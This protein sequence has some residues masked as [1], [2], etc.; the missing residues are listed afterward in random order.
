MTATEVPTV[1]E[2]ELSN[3]NRITGYLRTFGVVLVP[4]YSG[5]LRLDQLQYEHRDAFGTEHACVAPVRYRSGTRSLALRARRDRLDGS[6]PAIERFLGDPRI[7]AV[8]RGYLGFD[9][10]V[11]NAAYLMLD[12][13]DRRDHC[14][15]RPTFSR[16][17]E[18][19]LI[20]RT[21]FRRSHPPQAPGVSET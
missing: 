4:A 6:L 9:A 8:A 13:L 15:L 19:A 5:G 16:R 12:R 11:N 21:G 7:V 2:Q 17:W 20:R 1:T 3:V 18:P 14:N 10:C